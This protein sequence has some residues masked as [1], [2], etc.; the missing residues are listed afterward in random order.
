MSERSLVCS[1]TN[2]LGGPRLFEYRTLNLTGPWLFEVCGSD[3]AQD[4]LCRDFTTNSLY[5]D[6]NEHT[7]LDPTGRGLSDLTGSPRRLVT[8]RETTDPAKQAGLVLRA[9]KF[10]LRWAPSGDLSI[11]E[12]RQWADD[13]PSDW[14]ASLDATTWRRL[15]QDHHEYVRGHSPDEQ[16]EAARRLGPSAT[17]LSTNSWAAR[18]DREPLDR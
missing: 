9:I 5:Y 3:L 15:A 18:H 1:A 14:R 6:P 13:L 2:R 4:A 8:L 12:F 7:L 10:T 11:T 16:R 17:G